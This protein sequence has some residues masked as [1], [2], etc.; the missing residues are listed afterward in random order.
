MA[1]IL[2]DRGCT[3]GAAIVDVF[4]PPLGGIVVALESGVLQSFLVSL[5]GAVV[6]LAGVGFLSV[7]SSLPALDWELLDLA[8]DEL[9]GF[10]TATEMGSSSE[11]LDCLRIL[12]RNFVL[13]FVTTF[14]ILKAVARVGFSFF[15]VE[16]TF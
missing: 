1:L 3:T 10:T 6:L 5:L 15:G 12:N 14:W 7:V 2:C 4:L 13:G 16:R 11:P 9:R 8:S